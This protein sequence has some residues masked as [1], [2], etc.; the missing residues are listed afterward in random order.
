MPIIQTAHSAAPRATGTARLP[1]W[2]LLAL[3]AAAFTAASTEQLPAGL[4]PQMSRSLQVSEARV[5]FLV[6]SYAAA[7]FLAAVPLTAA[8]RGLPRRPVLIGALTG[9]ALC[10]D[11]GG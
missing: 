1:L 3:S 4:L 8:L 2:G 9:F 10:N 11:P 5:G 6:T 7:S